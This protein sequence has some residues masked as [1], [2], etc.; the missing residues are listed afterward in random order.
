MF[1]NVIER[2]IAAIM[3]GNV[4][5]R[6]ISAIM[7]SNVMES[8]IANLMSPVF[9]FQAPEDI[10]SN[11]ARAQG[12]VERA[13]LLDRLASNVAKRKRT[14]PQKFVG[15]AR[16]QTRPV[17]GVQYMKQLCGLKREKTCK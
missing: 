3:F 17:G 2:W 1:G 12:G 14:M 8:C 16:P 13:I 7:F 10:S 9:I 5:E 11:G 6:C 15:K 4:I